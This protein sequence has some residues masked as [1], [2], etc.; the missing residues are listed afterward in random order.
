MVGNMVGSS[1]AMAPAFVIGQHC[2][3]VDLD[4]P[5]FLAADR[6]PTIVYDE[7]GRVWCDDAVWGGPQRSAA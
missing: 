3:V 1:L 7:A 5:T 6:P 4:G 2:D